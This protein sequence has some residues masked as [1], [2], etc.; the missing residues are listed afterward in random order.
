MVPGDLDTKSVRSGGAMALFMMGYSPE[1]IMILGRWSSTAF[2]DYI[3]PQTLEWT[4][5]MSSDMAKAPRMMD[6][7]RSHLE[8]SSQ[9]DN[10][11]G[12]FE[13]LPGFFKKHH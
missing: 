13:L 1:K 11:W 9:E 6:L 10:K 3:R 2:M 8:R 4:S 7:N 5:L 12:T